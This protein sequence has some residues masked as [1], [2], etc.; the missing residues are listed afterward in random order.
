M[1]GHGVFGEAAVDVIAGE[2]SF[3]TEVLAVAQAVAALSV[4]P[5]QPGNADT[6]A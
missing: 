5:A 4:R 1:V 3:V 6:V 2:T